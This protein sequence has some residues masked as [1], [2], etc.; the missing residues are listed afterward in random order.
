MLSISLPAAERGAPLLRTIARE[1]LGSCVLRPIVGFAA[2]F[3]V[4]KC[5]IAALRS[6]ANAEAA[7]PLA[8]PQPLDA[9]QPPPASR[10]SSA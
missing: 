9:P 3:W 2:P 7:A 5:L 1:L 6:P 4:N 10:A 8:E